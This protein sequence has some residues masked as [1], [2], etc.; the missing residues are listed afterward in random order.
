MAFF[1]TW[2]PVRGLGPLQASE[3][4]ALRDLHA[5]RDGCSRLDGRSHRRLFEVDGEGFLCE[6]DT[7]RRIHQ[8]GR[9]ITHPQHPGV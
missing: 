3:E 4:A 6:I 1:T 7:G 5:D 9:G 8:H 2:G